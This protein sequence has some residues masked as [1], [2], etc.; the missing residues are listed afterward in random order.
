[1]SKLLLLPLAE[2]I[3]EAQWSEAR[4]LYPGKTLL[5]I[6]LNGIFS[7]YYKMFS[8][9]YSLIFSIVLCISNQHEAH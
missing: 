8:T 4:R 2:V 3:P 5:Y 1:M 7:K 6:Y 9:I